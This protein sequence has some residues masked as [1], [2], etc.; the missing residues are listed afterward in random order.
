MK[1]NAVLEAKE[2]ESTPT[3]P[4]TLQEAKDWCKIEVSDDDT[5]IEELIVSARKQC[6]GFLCISLVDKTVSAVL[7]NSLGNIELPYGPIKTITS[8]T[9]SEGTVLVA[10]DTYKLRGFEFKKLESPCNEYLEAVYT[11]GYTTIPDNFKTAV[12]QQIAFLYENRGDTP[13][14]SQRFNNQN[15]PTQLSPMVKETLNPYRRVW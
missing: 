10:N 4:V 3:E 7:N 6:E 13:A 11:T 15:V 2:V 14:G 1:Y 12:L 5:L 9:D 8:I